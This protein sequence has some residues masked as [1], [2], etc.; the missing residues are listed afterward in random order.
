ML[1]QLAT[2]MERDLEARQRLR[3]AV[4]YPV[5][6][7]LAAVGIVVLMAEFVLPRLTKFFKQFGVK[8]PPLSA[9]ILIAISD[10]FKNQ[11]YVLPLVIVLAITAVVLMRSTLPGRRV[12]DRIFL[13]MWLIRDIVRYAAVERFCRI[14]G[15][16]LRAGVPLPE[17]MRAAIDSVNNTAFEEKLEDVNEALLQGDGM[18]GPIARTGIFP[19]PAVQMIRVGEETGS[20]DHQL[21]IAGAY[22]STELEFKLKKLMAV[23]EPAIIVFMGLIVGYVAVT[24][25]QSIYGMVHGANLGK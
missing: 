1:D 6:I 24:M 22:Y 4:A 7:A 2:Y 18:A 21:E 5:V 23:F 14:I 17:S 12:R 8:Q 16:M 11:W 10:F 3:S 9:R 15:G 25:V 20:L 13:R 19:Q